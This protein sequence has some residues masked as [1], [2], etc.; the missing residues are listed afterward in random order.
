MQMLIP[1]VNT[2]YLPQTIGFLQKNNPSVLHSVCFN[3][4]CLPFHK[5][6]LA[7]EL[8]HLFE[9][10]L[11]DQLCA[12]KVNNGAYCATFSGRTNWNW[13]KDPQGLFRIE[14]DIGQEELPL[15][16]IALKR[17]IFLVEKL[18]RLQKPTDSF[19]NHP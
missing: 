19:S 12:L 3:D 5:E 18:L 6:V 11:L 7:T 15:L 1:L 2:R 8:G 9:H 4:E 17:T 13:T 14:I 16:L 10:L